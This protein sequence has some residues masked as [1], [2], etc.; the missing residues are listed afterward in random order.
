MPLSQQPASGTPAASGFVDEIGRDSGGLTLA[1]S[2]MS[3]QVAI[4]LSG[5]TPTFV[6][7]RPPDYRIDWDA[8][9]R[10]ITP[11]TRA[12]VLNSP[13]NPTGMILGLEKK[14]GL[15][16]TAFAQKMNAEYKAKK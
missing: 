2:G 15:A 3:G 10:A 6:T 11:R 13:H 14:Y 1:F 16:N 7:L 5:G 9:R 4:Q 12:I 8:A